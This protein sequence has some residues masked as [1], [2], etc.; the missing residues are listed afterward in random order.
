MLNC[1]HSWPE[2]YFENF[3]KFIYTLITKLSS[4]NIISIFF[5]QYLEKVF[6]EV[7]SDLDKM[8]K[9][10]YSELGPDENERI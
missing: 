9:I 3:I 10:N 7:F 4:S 2:L 5:Y 8:G 6:W 1:V